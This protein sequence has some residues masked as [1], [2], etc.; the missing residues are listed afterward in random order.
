MG[1]CVSRLNADRERIAAE[2]QKRCDQQSVDTYKHFQLTCAKFSATQTQC[3]ERSQKAC[4]FQ[5]DAFAKCD[6][7]TET[8]VRAD[9]LQQATR[10]CKSE[11]LL[12]QANTKALAAIPEAAQLA[13]TAR[14]IKESLP[15]ASQPFLDKGTQDVADATEGVDEAQ[16][17]K[18][19]V[20][21]LKWALGLAADNER[22]DADTLKKSS[23]KIAKSIDVLSGLVGQLSD[24]TARSSLKE[25][26]DA[27]K[28]RQAEL[29]RLAETKQKRAHGILSFIL[30]Q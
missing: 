7:L 21:G 25:Q 8:D 16:T 14:S 28:A 26:I 29:D 23:E 1:A 9:M 15:E 12:S 6:A 5:E 30:R 4:A 2:S 10:F 27:L 11:R 20:Y 24:E 18:G 19:L 13:I 22:K 3:E 17:N